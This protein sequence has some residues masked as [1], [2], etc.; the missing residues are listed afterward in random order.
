[1]VFM[2]E[3]AKWKY[4]TTGLIDKIKELTSTR[5]SWLEWIF[6]RLGNNATEN[7]EMDTPYV[8][9]SCCYSKNIQCFMWKSK[10]D[11]CH[12]RK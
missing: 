9:S 10:S 5:K 7:N 1:M 3:Q 6:F 8:F 2:V 12:Q 11:G 4:F